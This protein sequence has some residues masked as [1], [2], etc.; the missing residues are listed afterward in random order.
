MRALK[1]FWIEVFVFLFGV[2]SGS[3]AYL[4][5]EYYIAPTKEQAIELVDHFRMAE[6]GKIASKA[7][8]NEDPEIAIWAM[9]SFIDLQEK[10]CDPLKEV[11]KDSFSIYRKDLILAYGRRAI[12][13]KA[14]GDEQKY[15]NSISKAL[16]YAK[17]ENHWRGIKNAEDL[18]SMVNKC[19]KF[20]PKI[21]NRVEA[22]EK[23]FWERVN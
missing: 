14:L 12:V 16:S 23:E 1:R 2:V 21:Q 8:T 10:R 3:A 5:S 19:S 15:K 7:L 13:A 9:D 6:W 18:L 11:N 20:G 22:I 4:Y 17:I